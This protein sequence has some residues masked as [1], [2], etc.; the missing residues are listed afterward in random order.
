MGLPGNRPL[1]QNK[2]KNDEE[3]KAAMMGTLKSNSDLC[4][5]LELN[6]TRIGQSER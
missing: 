4:G 1:K 2:E 3:E 6:P 5:Q